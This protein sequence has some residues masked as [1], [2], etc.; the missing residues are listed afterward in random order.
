MHFQERR[1]PIKID[2]GESIDRPADGPALVFPGRF[3]YDPF[4]RHREVNMMEIGRRMLAITAAAAIA[5]T[6]AL[7]ACEKQGPAE[8]AGQ[9]VDR[10]VKDAKDALKDLS[11]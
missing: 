10:A 9:S 2:S 5:S 8:R 7:A 1:E 3:R 11:R 6:G 4:S